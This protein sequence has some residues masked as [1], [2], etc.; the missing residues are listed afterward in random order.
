MENDAITMKLDGVVSL[1]D[2]AKALSAFNKLVAAIQIEVLGGEETVWVVE[3]LAA[4]SAKTSLKGE[5]KTSD[6]AGVNRITKYYAETITKLRQGRASELSEQIRKPI[7]Q[8]LGLINGRVTSVAFST[9]DDEVVITDNFFT[10][11]DNLPVIER[12]GAIKGRIETLIARKGLQFSLYEHISNKR[13]SCSASQQFAEDLRSAW[14]KTAIV[15]GWIKRNP[16]T[17]EPMSIAKITKIE[18]VPPTPPNG[19]WRDA[20]GIAPYHGDESVEDRIRRGRE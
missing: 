16:L 15:E 19:S 13:I 5:S 14:G 11:E 6:K 3:D 1:E 9:G 4:G 7:E 18:V 8:L 2:Y 12:F 10:V 17:G 20:I